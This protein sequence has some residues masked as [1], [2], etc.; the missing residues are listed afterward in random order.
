[1]NRQPNGFHHS[2]FNRSID[3]QL[4]SPARAS[5]WQS[6]PRATFTSESF[7][8]TVRAIAGVFAGLATNQPIN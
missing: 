5:V 6:G 7:K 8:R 3:A 4:H 2:P 1:M